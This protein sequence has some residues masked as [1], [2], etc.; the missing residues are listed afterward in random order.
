MFTVSKEGKK[1][2]GFEF[3]LNVSSHVIVIL[4][5]HSYFFLFLNAFFYLCNLCIIELGK[6]RDKMRNIIGENPKSKRT[7]SKLLNSFV[8]KEQKYFFQ[9]E[10]TWQ[11]N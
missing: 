9:R 4:I 8:G 6:K 5:I 1:E 10:L 11:T 2:I 3:S 7:L